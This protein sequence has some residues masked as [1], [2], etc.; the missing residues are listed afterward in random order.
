MNKTL[1]WHEK[2]KEIALKRQAKAIRKKIEKFRKK[3]C[4]C[5]EGNGTFFNTLDSEWG[6]CSVCFIAEKIKEMV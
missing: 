1:E 6:I 4:Y 3:K 5:S 2:D